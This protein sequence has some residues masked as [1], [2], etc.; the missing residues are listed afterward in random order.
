MAKETML[1][2]NECQMVL[3]MIENSQFTLTGTSI[4]PMYI[5]M[6]KLR[7]G[8]PEKQ[9]EPPAAEGGAPIAAPQPGSY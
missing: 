3:Q 6:Q 8:L 7:L 2:E 9:P 1:T 5:L 4:E